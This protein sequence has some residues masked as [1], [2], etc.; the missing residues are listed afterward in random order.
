MGMTRE[1]F[2][3][4]DAKE[5]ARDYK[6][7]TGKKPTQKQVK[8]IKAESLSKFSKYNSDIWSRFRKWYET[9]GHS[10]FLKEIK[11]KE[12]VRYRGSDEILD[13]IANRTLDKMSEDDVLKAAADAYDKKYKAAQEKIQEE[14][15]TMAQQAAL[16]PDTEFDFGENF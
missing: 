2:A 11:G 5:Y 8:A 4:K 12:Y 13:L 1:Q 7:S 3:E 14:Q 15:K 16:K 6:K 9:P 10:A